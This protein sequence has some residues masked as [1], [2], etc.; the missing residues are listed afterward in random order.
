MNPKKEIR[1]LQLNSKKQ[2]IV[3]IIVI[4]VVKERWHNEY[5]FLI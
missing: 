1:L 4:L 3:I 5:L 2:I